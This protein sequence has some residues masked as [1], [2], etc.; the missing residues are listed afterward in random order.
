MVRETRHVDDLLDIRKPNKNIA[1][2]LG[3]SPSK[4]LATGI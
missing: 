3:H 4:A 2:G 1:R